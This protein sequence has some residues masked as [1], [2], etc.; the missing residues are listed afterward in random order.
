MMKNQVNKLE[1]AVKKCKIKQLETQNIGVK[2]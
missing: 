2:E 1:Q